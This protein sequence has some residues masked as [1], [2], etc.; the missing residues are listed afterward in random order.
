MHP[1]ATAATS[2]EANLRVMIELL[3]Q[4]DGAAA[5][6]ASR[7]LQWFTPP[8]ILSLEVAALKGGRPRFSR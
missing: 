1:I 3:V 5:L 4:S 7:A 2:D 6:V 8:E